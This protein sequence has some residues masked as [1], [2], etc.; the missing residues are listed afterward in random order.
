ME[1]TPADLILKAGKLLA[2][3]AHWCQGALAR[4]SVGTS[5]CPTSKRARAW[6]MA[7]VAYHV[8]RVKPTDLKSPRLNDVGALLWHFQA[9][10]GRLYGMGFVGVNDTLGHAEVMKVLR[11][12]YR[13]TKQ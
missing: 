7:G 3:P 13:R 6:D 1:Q 10:A 2:N 8:A 4:T 5:V 9:A 11:L 12:A